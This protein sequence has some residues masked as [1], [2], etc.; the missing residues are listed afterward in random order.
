MFYYNIHLTWL[1]L[2][3]AQDDLLHVP[4]LWSL[5]CPCLFQLTK[6]LL[7]QPDLDSRVKVAVEKLMALGLFSDK[8]EVELAIRSFYR[9]LVIAEKYK[10]ARSYSG[11]VTLVK[12][13][14]ASSESGLLGE[15]YGLRQVSNHPRREIQNA[16]THHLSTCSWW[17]FQLQD[18]WWPSLYSRLCPLSSHYY[19]GLG[20]ICWHELSSICWKL[21][22]DL[23]LGMALNLL[24]NLQLS[25]H[26]RYDF[27]LLFT[28]NIHF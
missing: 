27:V 3:D 20:L 12:S 13:L 5:W 16:A 11:P 19:A 22:I 21:E 15:D 1:K 24:T 10:P 25:S 17:M 14:S 6:E 2:R 18:C 28:L 9:K 4:V 7:C 23:M 26:V 8:G